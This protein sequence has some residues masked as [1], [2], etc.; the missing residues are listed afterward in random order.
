MGL[1]CTPSAILEVSTAVPTYGLNN[2]RIT[3]LGD[4]TCPP[5]ASGAGALFD[6][7]ILPGGPLAGC[8]VDQWG[9]NGAS[10]AA[11]MTGGV[12]HDFVALKALSPAPKIVFF[13]YGINS[14]R[15]GSLTQAQFTAQLSDA[16]DQHV[17]A[18]SLASTVFIMSTPNTFLSTDPS[19]N[20]WVQPSN[21]YQ[22]YTDM[23]WTSYQAQIGRYRNVFVQDRQTR[24]FGR[25]CTAQSNYMINQIHADGSRGQPAWAYDLLRNFLTQ[26]IIDVAFP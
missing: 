22:T 12:T 24:I 16:V 21:A 26:H 7:W 10:L 1:T 9:E 17:A 8:T 18:P 14:V 4:S 25:Q 3:L 20:N 2:L 11:Y 5:V 6:S 23:L 19:G 15:L 13:G